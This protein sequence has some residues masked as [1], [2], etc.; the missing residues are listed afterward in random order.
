M[1]ATARP[2]ASFRRRAPRRDPYDVVLLACEGSKTE[3]NYLREARLVYRLSSL[4]IQI[5]QPPG[6][7]PLTIVNFAISQ[8]EADP[9][10]NRAYCVFDRDD[11]PNF[12]QAIRRADEYE[13]N[14]TGKLFVIPSVPCFEIWVLLHYRYTTAAYTPAGGQTACE[15]LIR[16]VR[17]HFTDYEKGHKT[18]FSKL[19][20]LF[21]QALVTAARLEKHNAD[22]DTL[23]PATRIHQLMN[24]LKGLRQS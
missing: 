1:R 19:S 17:Q 10:Y 13:R 22:T 18:V 16:E 12:A 6:N 15:R 5:Q 8:L 2:S 21:D 11:H 3:P 20:A 7:D 9:D 24:Y 14:N 23:N 4:N